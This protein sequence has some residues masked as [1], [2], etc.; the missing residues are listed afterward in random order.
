M[1]LHNDRATP[2]ITLYVRYGYATSFHVRVQ[3][4]APSRGCKKAF[5]EEAAIAL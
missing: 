3:G 4:P 5:A 2:S 1:R